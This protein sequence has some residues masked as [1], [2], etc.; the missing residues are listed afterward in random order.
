[1]HKKHLKKIYI[2]EMATIET[3]NRSALREQ[4]TF[5]TQFWHED[6]TPCA[7][8]LKFDASATTHH[9]MATTPPE[10]ITK[11]PKTDTQPG[12]CGNA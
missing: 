3:Y 12:V 4:F 8:S 6:E 5:N 11:P 9:Q 7:C 1:M 2:L 10:R